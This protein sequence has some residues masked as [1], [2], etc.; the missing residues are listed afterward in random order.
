VDATCP[1]VKASQLLARSLTGEGYRLFLAGEKRHGE[2]IGIQGYAARG[3]ALYPAADSG[4]IMAADPGEAGAA[5]AELYDEFERRGIAVKTAL[6]GQT[7]LTPGEYR[8]IG[9]EIRRFFPELRICDTICGATRDRQ[10]AL[11]VLCG[12]VEGLIIAGGRESANTRRLLAI[13]LAQGKPAW[14][15][16]RPEDIPG[17]AGACG[18]LGLS[19]GASTPDEVINRIEAVLGNLAAPAAEN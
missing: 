4:C 6:I 18:T 10:E 7:T 8:A 14:L 15:V 16:E 12:S 5:A 13:A 2:L 11:K 17:E 1:K 3:R 9:E 19:A